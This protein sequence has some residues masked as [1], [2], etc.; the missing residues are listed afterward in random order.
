M[1]KGTYH[2]S[3]FQEK[4]GDY[5]SIQILPYTS[6]TYKLIQININPYRYAQIH[7]KRHANTY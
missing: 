6:N 5:V 4:N 2:N 3:Q 1:E 7:K